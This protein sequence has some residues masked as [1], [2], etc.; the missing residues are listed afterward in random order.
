MVPQCRTRVFSAHRE[1]CVQLTTQRGRAGIAGAQTPVLD[2][3]K[4]ENKKWKEVVN[5]R[6]DYIRIE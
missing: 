2:E 5:E 6:K 4:W 3:R 1:Q